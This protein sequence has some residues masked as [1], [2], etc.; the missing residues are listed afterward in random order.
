MNHEP[1]QQPIRTSL[2]RIG[3]DIAVLLDQTMLDLIGATPE[4]AFKV[5][6]DG[7]VIVLTPVSS[8]EIG[9]TR[10]H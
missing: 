4:T 6:T 3:R 10:A 7:R 9:S 1:Q 5:S 8:E 2:V